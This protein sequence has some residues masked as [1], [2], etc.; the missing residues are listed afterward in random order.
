[1]LTRSSSAV[2][3]NLGSQSRTS[4]PAFFNFSTVSFRARVTGGVGMQMPSFQSTAILSFFRGST[5]RHGMGNIFGSSF[6]GC[7]STMAFEY[8]VISSSVFPM[9]PLT[10]CTASWPARPDVHLCVV[11]R[12]KDGRS[13]NIPVHAAGI[14]KLPPCF[15]DQQW[16][17]EGRKTPTISVPTPRGLPPNVMSA[18]SPPEDP[19]DVTLRFNGLTV[20]PNV[21]FTDSAYT[22]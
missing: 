15:H 6:Q 3:C 13:V 8:M 4:C 10:L 18:D 21:L 2:G 17:P 16:N 12:P 19:P 20:R 1:M 22:L 5:D 11:K 9:G 14:R 7:A